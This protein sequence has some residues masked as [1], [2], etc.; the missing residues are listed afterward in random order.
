ML[1]FRDE[2]HVARWCHQ[3]NMPSGAILTLGTAW[4]LAQG[5][6]SADRGAAGWHRPPLDAVEALFTTLGLT[7]EFWALR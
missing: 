5:W 1:F 3:W 6:F 7:G 4:Q 2:E